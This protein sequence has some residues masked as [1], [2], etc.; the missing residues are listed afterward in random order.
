[1]VVGRRTRADRRRVVRRPSGGG[2]RRLHVQRS[3]VSAGTFTDGAIT[4]VTL[5]QYATN[6]R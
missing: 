4:G 6:G 1:M 5:L 2:E 3:V